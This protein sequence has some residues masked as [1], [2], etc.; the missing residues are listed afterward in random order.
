MATEDARKASLDEKSSGKEAEV[1]QDPVFERPTGLKG[2]YAH[3][4]TQVA[5]LGF[6]CFMCPGLF[7]ALN[8]LGGGGQLDS[9][10]SA[11]ANSAVYATFAFFAFFAGSINNKLGSRATLLLGTFGYALYVGSYLALNIHPNAGGFVIGAGAVLGISAGLLWAAQGSLM[12]AYPTEDQKGQFISIFWTIFNLGAVIGAAVSLGLNFNSDGNSVGNGTYIAFLILTGI[13]VAIPLLMIDPAKMVRTDGTRVTTSRHPSWKSELYG[14]YLVLRNDPWIFLLVPMFFAS[15][16][17]YTW[18]FNVYNG[19]MFDIKARSLNNFLYWIAQ[20]IGSIIM[21]FILDQKKI[22]RTTRAYVGWA[23]LFVAV[24]FIHIWSFFYQKDL[25]RPADPENDP[26]VKISIHTPG[27]A[28]K[29][30]LYFFFGMVDAIW[31]ITAYWL[32]G[33]MSNDPAKLAHMSG[34]YKALQSAGAAVA[35]RADAVGVSYSSLFIST[36]VLLIG[37]MI[38]VLPMIYLR[39]KDHTEPEDET[40]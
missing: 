8:G 13:G 33:A 7:N 24:W 26:F 21:G 38:L 10:T 35:W 18:Q 15:N 34:I 22:R 2:F 12:L 11:N 1:A 29:I 25:V 30:I 17:F 27:Y 6:V 19:Y 40:L 32:M 37:G 31:Q 16:W 28:A 5:M 23:I 9:K 36:W 20:I 4:R 3:P 39:V 14:L